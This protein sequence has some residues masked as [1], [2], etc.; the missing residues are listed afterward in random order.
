MEA[1]REP[2]AALLDVGLKHG[3]ICEVTGVSMRFV[4]KVRTI[5]AAGGSFE[6]KP[7]SGQPPGI[8]TEDFLCGLAAK[9]EADP[10]KSMQKLTLDL[11]VDE[12][13]IRNAVKDLGLKSYIRR[14]R[15]LLTAKSKASRVEKG[16]K[17]LSFLKSKS[18]PTELD[19]GP[20]PQRQERPVPHV[21]GQQPPS[22]Q[23]DQAPG[24]CHDAGHRGLGRQQ[25]AAV[26]V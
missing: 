19:R 5:V 6:R 16:R 18:P 12:K 26:L 11:E 22:H 15:Q 23:P 21:R 3:Q 14:R 2:V 1:K 13:T 17:I 8:R 7:G 10:T 25:D 20:G 24:Q 9:I 4:A